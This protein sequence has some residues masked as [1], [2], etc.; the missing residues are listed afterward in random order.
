MSDFLQTEV[1][2]LV[3]CQVRGAAPSGGGSGATYFMPHLQRHYPQKRGCQSVVP[4]G[5]TA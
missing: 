1:K 2:T 4:V 3:V 5:H